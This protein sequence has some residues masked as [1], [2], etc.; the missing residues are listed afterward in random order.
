MGE[1]LWIE[2]LKANRLRCL[3]ALRKRRF[4]LCVVIWSGRPTFRMTKFAALWLKTCR[5]VVYNENADSF[6]IGGRS[7]RQL[8]SH[9]RFRLRG[10]RSLNILYPVLYPVGCFYLISRTLYLIARSRFSRGSTN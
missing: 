1:V 9:L 7:W 3:R 4:D 6:V 2:Q 10:W 8:V 5:I